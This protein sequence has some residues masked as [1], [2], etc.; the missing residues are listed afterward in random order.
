MLPNAPCKSSAL[1]KQQGPPSPVKPCSPFRLAIPGSPK[2][3]TSL[4]PFRGPS[5][6]PDASLQPTTRH[7]VLVRSGSPIADPA[8]IASAIAGAGLAE[9]SP[10]ATAIGCSPPAHHS[11]ESTTTGTSGFPSPVLADLPVGP[12]S[13]SDDMTKALLSEPWY[14][15]PAGVTHHSQSVFML[16]TLRAQVC[17]T[18]PALVVPASLVLKWF[19]ASII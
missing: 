18:P 4:C 10:N 6:V 5:S 19:C 7:C 17:A 11:K 12:H 2:P 9:H 13:L 8:L 1:A 15:G 16:R 14:E 3:F